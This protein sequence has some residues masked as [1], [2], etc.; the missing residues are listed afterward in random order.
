MEYAV[1]DNRIFLL[2][3]WAREREREIR[4]RTDKT[5]IVRNPMSA[6]IVNVP[7]GRRV[8]KHFGDASGI[9]SY[10]IPVVYIISIGRANLPRRRRG[11]RRTWNEHR[12]VASSS[13]TPFPSSLA[14]VRDTFYAISRL[15]RR[16]ENAG[17]CSLSLSFY[18]SNHLGLTEKLTENA[19]SRT[20]LRFLGPPYVL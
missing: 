14:F 3:E 11:R 20:H 4:I 16:L 19:D 15:L 18:I 6:G 7:Y 2:P 12:K 13:S 9:W 5:I 10:G 17:E 8:V 1:K